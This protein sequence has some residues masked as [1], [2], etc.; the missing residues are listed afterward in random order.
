MIFWGLITARGNSKRLPDKNIKK[1]INKPLIEYSYISTEDTKLDK[2]ILSTNCDA[3]IEIG[4]KYK[5]ID[6]PYKRPYELSTD[7]ATSIDVVKHCLNYYKSTNVKLPDYILIL[8]PTCPQ[9]IKED[10]NYIIDYL[11][12][13]NINE[14]KDENNI[15]S[16]TTV[17][18]I[19]NIKNLLHNEKTINNIFYENGL[20]FALSI[21]DI[22]NNYNKLII[23]T[24]LPYNNV[25]QLEYP[26]REI[27]D[28]DYLEEFEYCEF[29][30]KKNMTKIKKEI[31]INNR[32]INEDSKPFI[33]AEVGINHNSDMNK[34]KKMIYDAYYAGCECVKFQCHIPEAEMTEHAK[35]IIPS[36]A[37]EDI[38]KIIEKSSLTE[39][40]EILLK[41]LVEKLG[42]IYLCTPFSIEAAD[43]LE[44][45]GVHAYKIGSGEMNNLQLIE[46]VAKFGKPMLV[47]TGM[48]PLD[49]IRKTVEVLETYKVKY[50][51]FHCV[52]MYPTPYDKVNLPG[53][54][55]LKNEFPNAMIGLSDHSIGITSCLGAYMKGCNIFEKHYTSYKSWPGPDIEISITPDELKSLIEQLDILKKC[56]KGE[57]RLKIQKEEQSTINFAFCT[58]TSTR[59][60]KVG[61]VLTKDD[62]IAKRPNIGD[63]LAEDIPKLIGKKILKAMKKGEK[64]YM[65]SI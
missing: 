10:I 22:Y 23:D 18:K 33:I 52:S 20:I 5:H 55:D 38:F 42:M 47:S 27:I 13:V 50:C 8:Q 15:N 46:H 28:I 65:D 19:K 59:D 12:S 54:D 7:T 57:G 24:S 51:L 56:N 1:L 43:R 49:K 44:K 48:N 39:D 32:I 14:N 6:I 21:K 61:H 34:A 4:K 60:L 17:S 9:R 45:I 62:I 29:L 53:I 25:I 37:N 16:L 3:C 31:I 26:N 35:N 63:F 36:N 30:M 11:E 41:E 64:F 58:L 40:Q 2:V